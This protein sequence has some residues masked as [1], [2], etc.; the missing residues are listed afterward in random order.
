MKILKISEFY[1]EKCYNKNVII[2]DNACDSKSVSLYLF[3]VSEISTFYIKMAK[4]Q[5][6]ELEILSPNYEKA[7]L[8][9]IDNIAAKFEDVTD[10]SIYSKRRI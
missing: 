5:T 8:L 9:S 2:N 3:T 1:F 6:H 4:F 10:V 7:S